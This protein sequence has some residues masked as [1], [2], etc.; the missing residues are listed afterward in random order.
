[1]AKLTL[2]IAALAAINVPVSGGSLGDK[3]YTELNTACSAEN[4]PYA[5][6]PE[7]KAKEALAGIKEKDMRNFLADCKNPRS[8]SRTVRVRERSGT[9]Q[10]VGRDAPVRPDTVRC[11][12]Q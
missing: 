6:V 1:M 5:G 12:W 8:G 4:H 7:A 11:Y 9:A 2:V 3:R 10:C